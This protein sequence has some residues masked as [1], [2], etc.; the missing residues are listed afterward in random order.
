MSNLNVL[1]LPRVAGRIPLAI[2]MKV[3]RDR[4]LPEEIVS[5]EVVWVRKES[6]SDV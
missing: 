6:N 3:E 5:S 4:E 1:G 2:R